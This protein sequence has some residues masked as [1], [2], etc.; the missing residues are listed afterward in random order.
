VRDQDRETDRLATLFADYARYHRHPANKLCHYIGIPLI[1]F[2][3]V[4]LL[5]R[6]PLVEVAG[7]S[8]S[9]AVPIALLAL[10]YDL[11]LSPRLTLPF[12]AFVAGSLLLAP[13]VGVRSLTAGFVG[14]WALQFLGHYAYEK[15]SPAFFTN[16]QQLL[17]GP[18]WILETLAG[19]PSTP[20]PS[21]DSARPSK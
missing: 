12:A 7:V 20:K 19:T 5:A 4:G 8:V 3:L 13:G 6:V 17:V 15:K 14:G 11:L 1:V 10:G 16:L 2:T 9:L 21:P 18:L